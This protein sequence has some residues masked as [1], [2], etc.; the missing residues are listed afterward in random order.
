[1]L[2]GDSDRKSKPRKSPSLHQIGIGLAL[3]TVSLVLSLGQTGCAWGLPFKNLYPYARREADSFLTGEVDGRE[4]TVRYPSFLGQDAARRFLHE[5]EAF[6]KERESDYEVLRA[7]LLAHLGPDL[8][9]RVAD[10]WYLKAPELE[11]TWFLVVL[12]RPRG[13]IWKGGP[14]TAYHILWGDQAPFG[15]EDLSRR[16]SV[17]YE[18]HSKM[19]FVIRDLETS[20]RNYW[21]RWLEEGIGDFVSL[22]FERWKDKKYDGGREILAR[23]TWLRP[24][25]QHKLMGWL[26]EGT[27]GLWG[28][29]GSLQNL[30]ERDW[31]SD[32]LYKG[33]LGLVLSLENELGSG[34]LLR[35]FQE[36]IER[37]PETDG[38]FVQ[39][40]EKRVGKLLFDV[41]LMPAGDR[42]KLL[43]TLLDRAQDACSQRAAAPGGLPLAAIGHL[44]EYAPQV[45][46][47]LEQL[48]AC[49]DVE[50]SLQ[51]LA[52]LRYLGLV[53]PLREALERIRRGTKT[54][55]FAALQGDNRW[56]MAEDYVRS[57]ER[58][59]DWYLA[60][61]KHRLRSKAWNVKSPPASASIEL[62][63]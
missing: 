56:S 38:D 41:G 52:G 20:R 27:G 45:I 4:I 14:G 8:F 33:S 24:T 62:H 50:V 42:E 47:V 60:V 19:H 59:S 54:G 30:R 7:G 40:I 29:K 48:A 57:V 36:L 55:L 18:V 35:L 63:E 21:P 17:R 2:T 25:V 51:G 49:E 43:R 53:Q 12:P 15:P 46:P 31:E 61:P 37:S 32:L 23:L 11:R 10:R 6:Q 5:L 39:V 26:H 44:P 13:V 9:S 28:L 58:G 1:M 22:H 3:S 34:G 16:S